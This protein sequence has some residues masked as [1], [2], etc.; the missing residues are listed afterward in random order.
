MKQK[1]PLIL[2]CGEGVNVGMIRG[3]IA[4]AHPSC[5]PWG[6]FTGCDWTQLGESEARRH[7][8]ASL[9]N[10]CLFCGKGG[11]DQP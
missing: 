6:G 5:V 8:R 9:D 4:Y 7:N 2:I 11:P 10:V 3:P 1:E